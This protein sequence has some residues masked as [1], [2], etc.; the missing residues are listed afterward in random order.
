MPFAT[1]VTD[2]GFRLHPK[3]KLLAAQLNEMAVLNPKRD[4]TVTN[5]VVEFPAV[6]EATNGEIPIEKSLTKRL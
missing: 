6:V 4:V 5:V 1:G 3:F 2:V